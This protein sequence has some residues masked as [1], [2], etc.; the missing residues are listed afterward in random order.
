MSNNNRPTLQDIQKAYQGLISVRND[1]LKIQN[2][3]LSDDEKEKE[4]EP[5]MQSISLYMQRSRTLP[6]YVPLH[7]QLRMA[8]E[9][10]EKFFVGYMNVSSGV[11]TCKV[12][13]LTN[14]IN[15]DNSCNRLCF[16]FYQNYASKPEYFHTEHSKYSSNTEYT[17]KT[18]DEMGEILLNTYQKLF[19]NKN[20]TEL[21]SGSA[22]LKYKEIY[23]K[24]KSHTSD[25]E[26][27]DA[28]YIDQVLEHYMDTKIFIREFAPEWQEKALITMM[29]DYENITKISS[30][31]QKIQNSDISDEE[32]KAKLQAFMTDNVFSIEYSQYLP[33]CQLREKQWNIEKE[34]LGISII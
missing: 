26:L 33:N 23:D 9:V 20:P 13:L 32:K 6:I 11:I 25:S 1:L 22:L 18:S 19:K 24:Y 31:L 2:S 34:N 3:N 4:A 17:D 28:T 10:I 7:P 27:I 8:F 15:L 14:F 16:Y 21:L 5:Y 29:Q 12:Q 30:V